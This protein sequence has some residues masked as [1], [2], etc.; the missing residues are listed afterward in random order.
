MKKIIFTLLFA[1]ALAGCSKEYGITRRALQ[2]LPVSLPTG[3]SG[4]VPAFSN[5]E[6]HNLKTV[7]E[8][9]SI[10]LLQFTVVYK[11]TAD[12]S[13]SI[14]L[15]YIYLFDTMMSKA[16]GEMIFNENFKQIPCMP[17]DLIKQN[18]KEVKKRK[19]S[20]YKDL[21]GGTIPV[22]TPYDR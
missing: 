16:F 19:E 10:C 4:F 21:Y 20:V 9:D 17:D 22:R 3:L 14:D 6:I 2:Q 12:V 15:R 1:V 5:P 18:Q 7:Y 8:N 13:Q 11:D